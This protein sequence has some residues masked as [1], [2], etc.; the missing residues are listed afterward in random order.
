MLSRCAAYHAPIVTFLDFT[1]LTTLP[2]AW[3][4]QTCF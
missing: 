4:T 1:K 2:G 3:H